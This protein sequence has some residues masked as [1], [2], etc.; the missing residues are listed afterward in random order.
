[1]QKSGGIKK[2]KKSFLMKDLAVIFIAALLYSCSFPKEIQVRSYSASVVKID[3]VRGETAIIHWEAN[4]ISFLE[5]KSLPIAEKP[6]DR[7]LILLP[8]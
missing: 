8:R 2:V 5:W 4:E 1:M 3:T 7:K 6:G